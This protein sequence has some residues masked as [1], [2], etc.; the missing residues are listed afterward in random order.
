LKNKLLESINKTDLCIAV[1]TSLSGHTADI[2]AKTTS[3]NYSKGL[4]KGLIIINIQPTQYDEFCTLKIYGIIDNVF[5]LLAN[6]IGMKVL[7][8][9]KIFNLKGDIFNIPYDK[10]GLKNNDKSIQIN[11]STG[12]KVKLANGTNKGRIGVVI[13][14]NDEGH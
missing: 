10:N 4:G 11:L 12:K 2:I 6:K 3:E 14:K 13:G 5:K 8:K 1:G 7:L 9:N